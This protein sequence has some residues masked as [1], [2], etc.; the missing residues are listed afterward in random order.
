[1]LKDI[2]N[3]SSSSSEIRRLSVARLSKEATIEES[4]L[5]IYSKSGLFMES[6]VDI[7]SSKETE[8]LERLGD[9]TVLHGAR[10]ALAVGLG[11]ASWTRVT[12]AFFT[13][14]VEVPLLA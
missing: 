14:D 10:K 2:P 5:S 7:V 9:I 4:P 6:H 12:G 3:V 11:A 8:S 1:M 13:I